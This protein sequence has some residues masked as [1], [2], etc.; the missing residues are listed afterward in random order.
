VRVALVGP[1]HPQKGGIAQH[2]TALGRELEAAGHDVVH[3]SWQ[4][5][6]PRRL[7]P[8]RIEVTGG[9]E[10]ASPVPVR[11]LLRWWDPAGWHRVSRLVTGADRVVL[12]LPATPHVPALRTIARRCAR[13]G[14]PTTLIAHNVAPHEPR[15]G[16]R[17]LIGSLVRSVDRVVVHTAAEQ[18]AAWSL[19]AREVRRCALPP[20]LPDAV[21]GGPPSRPGGGV[22]LAFGLVRPYK[23][24]DVAIRALA[25]VP[26]ARLLVAGEF[27]TPIEE[28]RA[29]AH[30]CGVTDRVELRPGYVAADAIPELVAECDFL[31]APYLTATG[32][33]APALARAFG[34]PVI[35]S[36]TGALGADVRDGVDGFVVAPGD[37][38]GLAEAWRALTDDATWSRLSTAASERSGGEAASRWGD[39]VRA[40]VDER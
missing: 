32:S 14:T 22:A 31:L 39:Y 21:A 29:L 24:I 37:V 6:Y 20:A 35:V 11:A 27:W 10:I 40:V 9:P 8:G 15:P 4:E 30:R 34:R 12:V 25:E 16:D 19:G 36:D 2:T 18:E 28:L 5:P 1:A 26:G 33:Q 23:G 7:Y 13:S 3:V 17:L 38:S